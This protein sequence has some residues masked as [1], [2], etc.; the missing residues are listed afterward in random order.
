M[1]TGSRRSRLLCALL[2]AWACGATPNPV[3]AAPASPERD[4]AI[5]S[6]RAAIAQHDAAKAVAAEQ[7]FAQRHPEDL[8]FRHLEPFLYVMVGD[9]AGWEHARGDL[10]NTWLRTR[11]GAPPPAPPSFTI[12][13]FK[14]GADTVITDQCYER[15]GRFGV[16]YRF[17]VVGPDRRVNSFFT[18]ES[19]DHDNQIAREMGQPSPVFT[20]DHF[21]PGVHETVAMLPGL[22]A[23]A[24]LR[25]RV[26]SYIAKPQPLSASRNGSSVLSN[27]D[28][29]AGRHPAP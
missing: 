4:A 13:M 22:P 23:Y 8:D 28:C 19:P 15:A 16:I 7:G 11:D 2:A 24:D 6:V 27:E 17:T 3:A 18:V 14:V 9:H 1:Q 20:L 5:A 12:D 21:V 29:E 26:L 10:L 25:Q